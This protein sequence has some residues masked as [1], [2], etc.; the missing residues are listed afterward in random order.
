MSDKRSFIATSVSSLL[1]LVLVTVVCV[2]AGYG[3]DP[4]GRPTDPSPKG[5]KPS[6]KK[7]P[8]S[9]GE[10]QP[11]TVTLTVLSDPPASE[12]FLNGQSRGVTNDEG[13]IQIEK[14]PL[15]RYSVEVRKDGFRPLLKGFQAGTD[16]PTLVFKLD[17]DID[18]YVKDFDQ[19]V[20]AGKLAGPETPNALELVGTLAKQFGDRP[21]LL[22]MRGVLA[23]KLAEPAMP[24][25]N[26][27][28]TEPRGVGRA[29]VVQVLDGLM[30]SITLKGD[31]KRIQAEAAYLR[32][33]LSL[34]QGQSPGDVG[35]GGGEAQAKNSGS[36]ARAEFESAL[37]FDEAF[38][39]ARYQLGLLLLNEGNVAGAEAELVRV[40]QAEPRWASAQTAL[41]SVY[42]GGGKF[43]EAIEAYRRAIAIDSKST[44]AYAGL[45]LAR[46]AKGEKDGV[47]DI[48]RAGQLDPS[49]ALP[50]LNLGIVLSQSKSK[51]DLTRAEEELKKAI[52]QNGNNLE[53]PNRIAELLL[54]DVQKRKK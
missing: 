45:G 36:N 7:T 41:G 24:V 54:A 31:D 40:S 47:K 27:T 37:K 5:K 18:R 25:I 8:T 23:A 28:V 29:E 11:F 32:G 46:W 1:T 34:Q 38:T 52:Q 21:E 22:R 26:R 50:H 4:S 9:K 17:P 6:T 3:Q 14:L 16:S 12:V 48:E 35:Q 43:K 13:R 42:Y 30:N 44:P 20:A 15:L 53:F 51:K 2:N 33:V 39:P 10:P 49:S 19:L